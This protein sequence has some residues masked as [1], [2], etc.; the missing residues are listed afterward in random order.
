MPHLCSSSSSSNAGSRASF[1]VVVTLLVLG[2]LLSTALFVLRQQLQQQQQQQCC[3]DGDELPLPKVPVFFTAGVTTETQR[4][5]HSTLK[6]TLEQY[7]SELGLRMKALHDMTYVRLP[8]WEEEEEEEGEFDASANLTSHLQAR[9]WGEFEKIPQYWQQNEDLLERLLR[10]PDPTP[11]L[12]PTAHE[13][14]TQ[15]FKRRREKQQRSTSSSSSSSSSS[16][17]FSSSYNDAMQIFSHLYRDWTDDGLELRRKTYTPILRAIARLFPPALPR[18]AADNGSGMEEETEEKRILVPG[19]GLGRLAFEIAFG[20]LS[21]QQQQQHQH[22]QHQQHE[23]QQQCF[24]VTAMDISPVMVAATAAVLD[25]VLGSASQKQEQEEKGEEKRKDGAKDSTNV[26]YPFLHDPLLNQRSH[27]RRFHAISFPDAAAVKQ[28]Q[29]QRR[30]GKRRHHT[31]YYYYSSSSSSSSSHS[32]SSSL[33]L[34]LGNFL[35][36]PLHP[37]S[38]WPRSQ[39][40]I[41]TC[42][43]LDTTPNPLSYL[44]SIHSLLQDGGYWINLG[45]LNYHTT[46]P[47]GAVQ[48]TVDEIEIAA[49]GMGLRKVK[50]EGE[51]E[52]CAYRPEPGGGGGGVGGR[53]EGSAFLRVDVYQPV[54]GVYQKVTTK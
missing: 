54:M 11:A 31:D 22:Q 25:V 19:A 9:M 10:F 27:A 12:L 49:E 15:Q 3:D 21:Q 47:E 33:A 8:G 28:I 32:S 18:S 50:E 52:G 48:L 30:R 34:E 7:R 41:I 2:M 14:L 45:P 39:H 26:F 20:G 13:T 24:H 29:S 53:E 16:P 43:F 40:A 4:A 37:S 1:L 35:H 23:Q 38:S 17:I 6:S 46:L 51:L 42:F 44:R 36:L 5:A